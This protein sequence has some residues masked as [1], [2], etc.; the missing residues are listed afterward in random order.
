M[1]R[2]IRLIYFAVIYGANSSYRYCVATRQIPLVFSVTETYSRI[3]EERN[4][5]MKWNDFMEVDRYLTGVASFLHKFV[6]VHT[7]A[8][9]YVFTTLLIQ[10]KGEET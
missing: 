6:S 8:S 5:L 2:L 4:E 7:C 9:M 1:S 10:Q 3:D